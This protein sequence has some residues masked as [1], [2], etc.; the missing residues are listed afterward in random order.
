MISA[1]SAPLNAPG[2]GPRVDC[3]ASSTLGAWRTRRNRE[4]VTLAGL[5][6]SVRQLG[7]VFDLDPG[8]ISRIIQRSRGT[9][10]AN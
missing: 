4:I 5:G 6:R 3:G 7:D 8:H 2:K 9:Y 10:G 1:V